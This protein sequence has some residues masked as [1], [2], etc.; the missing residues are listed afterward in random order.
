[1]KNVS[2]LGTGMYVP[3]RVVT[4][5]DLTKVVETSDEWIASRTGIR[6]R[7]IVENENTIELAYQASLEAI[8]HANVKLEEIDLVI[9]GTVTPENVFPSTAS[10][11]QARLGLGEIMAFDLNAACSGFVYSLDV[12]D[13]MLRSGKFNKALVVGAEVLTKYVDWTDRNTCVLFGDGAG[14][15][16]LGEGTGD[17][18]DTS[19]HTRGDVEKNLYGAGTPLKNLTNDTGNTVGN[20]EMNGREIFKFA[21][22]QIPKSI[23][24]ILEKNDLTLDDIDYIVCHQA[25]ERIIESAANRLKVSMDKMF[26]NMDKYG[27]TSAASVPMALDEAI[28]TNKIKR[29]DTIVIIAFGAGL[30]WSTALI[31]Y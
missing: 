15:T 13:K 1:M 12:A 28:K 25:N 26:L 11:L 19:S 4:N 18:I 3:S 6:S 8:K 30:T 23:N 29:G 9:V 31:K 21:T 24:N 10:I 22:K 2:I 27:N 14:A 7:H 20:I 16:I 17:I 5:D